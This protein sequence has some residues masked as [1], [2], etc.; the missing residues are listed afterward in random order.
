MYIIPLSNN[1][2]VFSNVIKFQMLSLSVNY[3]LEYILKI[4]HICTDVQRSEMYSY[5]HFY[6]VNTPL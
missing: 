1:C 4:Y 3:A 6:N 5:I 2:S